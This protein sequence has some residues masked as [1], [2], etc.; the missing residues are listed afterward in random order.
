MN[1]SAPF[2]TLFTQKLEPFRGGGREVEQ[3]GGELEN[4]SKLN[5][6]EELNKQGVRKFLKI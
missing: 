2:K 4:S 6:Q 5:K 1:V 3:T